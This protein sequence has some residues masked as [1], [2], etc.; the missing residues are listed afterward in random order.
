M[1]DLNPSSSA[2]QQAYTRIQNE[3]LAGARD[4]LDDYLITHPNDADAWWLYAHAVDDPLEAQNALRTVLRLRPDYPGAR[5]LLGESEQLLTLD[6]SL[7]RETSSP[8]TET[9]VVPGPVRTEQVPTRIDPTIDSRS[10]AQRPVFL[11]AA[12]IVAALLIGA[13]VILT[14]QTRQPEITPTGT[15]PAATVPQIAGQ[16][17]GTEDPVIA[18]T[19]VIDTT[20]ET[21]STE[22]IGIVPESTGEATAIAET[23]TETQD[24][25]YAALYTA[26]GDFTVVENSAS[27]EDLAIGQTILVSVCNDAAQG[28]Q[29]TTINVLKAIASSSASFSELGSEFI[30]GRIVDCQRENLVLRTLAL[31]LESGAAYASGE[32]TDSQLLSQ[33]VPIN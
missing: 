26:L 4:L 8:T 32:L 11:V 31:P 20:S 13:A 1:N 17:T 3:D 33:L 6:P 12:L 27:T 29:G 18:G 7:Y 22:D 24:G 19:Q 16:P 25:Q 10:R 9:P 21:S 30:G 15:V 2:L 23:I 5:D 14:S 28:L